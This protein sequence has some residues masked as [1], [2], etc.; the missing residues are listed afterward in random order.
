MPRSEPTRFAGS[1]KLSR[2][3]LCWV[4][5]PSSNAT[6][7]FGKGDPQAV[8]HKSSNMRLWLPTAA[9]GRRLQRLLFLFHTHPPGIARPSSGGLGHAGFVF[10]GV[11]FRRPLL[12]SRVSPSSCT[13]SWRARRG[14]ARQKHLRRAML[15]LS[16]YPRPSSCFE[17]RAFLVEHP[18]A[19]RRMLALGFPYP[20]PGTQVGVWVTPFPP[21]VS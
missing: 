9:Q 1:N 6:G 13:K 17:T 2:I 12:I 7:R 10:S 15:G 19:L 18:A 8:S 16:E 14:F 20:I 21:S 4:R 11:G 3:A 5:Y